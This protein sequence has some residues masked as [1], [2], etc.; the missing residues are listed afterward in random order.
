MEK[1]FKV[2]RIDKDGAKAV[3]DDEWGE[4]KDTGAQLKGYDCVTE[5]EIIKAAS[6]AD[7]ILTFG[8]VIT[9][10]VMKSLPELKAVVRYGVGFDTVD[11]Q[12]AT[13]NN[14]MVV[15]IPDFCWEEVAN[16]VIMLILAQ[17]KK[18][19]KMNA[20]VKNGQWEKAKG[21]LAPMSCVHGETLGII[22]CGRIGR[23]VA[24]KAQCFGLN[25]IG[26]DAYLPKE[27]ASEA[28]IT[29]VSLDELLSR[30]DYITLH[31]ALTPETYH[32]LSAEQ[33][34][35]MKSNAVVINTSR[36]PTIDEAALISALGSGEIAAACL[37]VFEQEPVDPENPLLKMDNVIV[38]PH[39]ASYSDAAFTRLR[40]SAGREA[41]RMARGMMP[42]NIVNKGVKPKA[43]LLPCT[44]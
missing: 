35:K 30:S 23:T 9:R 13:D 17:S 40:A 3:L 20:M 7:V 36:G 12:A 16:H 44:D 33:F 5:D 39:S 22:G 27:I 43:K 2:A 1:I 31:T 8:G 34:K 29:L 15:N 21:E 24:K 37:D 14:I 26:Y 10:R 4:L 32:L 38:L 11:I 19:I 41:A 25:L 18:L 28:G 6:D 42:K